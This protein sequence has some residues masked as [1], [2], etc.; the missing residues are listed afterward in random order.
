MNLTRQSIVSVTK[1][2]VSCELGDESAI[3]N[4]KEGIYYGLDAIGTVIWK[5]LQT[6]HSVAEIQAALLEE[7]E[8]ERERCE[9]DLIA[10]LNE[11]LKAGLIE[12]R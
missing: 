5:L 7:Y 4:T 9:L 1:D 3:L 8:V 6:P 10:L 12:Q 11:L 2:Q